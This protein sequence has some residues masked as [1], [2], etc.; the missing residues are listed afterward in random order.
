MAKKHSMYFLHVDLQAVCHMDTLLVAFEHSDTLHKVAIRV[1]AIQPS[2]QDPDDFEE[3]LLTV[4]QFDEAQYSQVVDKAKKQKSHFG[5][6]KALRALNLNLNGYKG[7][8]LR[9]Q[10]ELLDSY[11]TVHGLKGGKASS[12][13]SNLIPYVEGHVFSTDASSTIAKLDSLFFKAK[14][15]ELKE[16]TTTASYQEV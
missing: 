12:M 9:V 1:F 4:R 3:T 11:K 10:V 13:A 5:D 8:Y 7:R 16:S 6:N 14:R 2:V 15:D